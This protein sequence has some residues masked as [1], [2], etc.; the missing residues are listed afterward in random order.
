MTSTPPTTSALLLSAL[1]AYSTLAQTLFAAIES[2]SSSSR[3]TITT[4]VPD[5]VS[6]KTWSTRTVPDI[7]QA[8]EQVDILLAQRITIARQHAANQ[9]KIDK[10]Q[11]QSK[12]RNRQCRRA[13]LELSDM[14][15]DLRD[16]LGTS[17]EQVKSTR[18]A[19]RAPVGHKVI[20]AY[21]HR[22]AKYTSAPPGYKLPQ[23][24]P[25]PAP[26]ANTEPAE[27]VEGQDGREEKK[28]TLGPEYNQFASRA[29]AYYDP[30]MPSMPQE[31]PFPSDAMMRQGVL[32]SAE[33][34]NGAQ[35]ALAPKPD[36]NDD[37]AEDEPQAAVSAYTDFYSQQQH[38][39]DADDD[40]FDLDLN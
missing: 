7:L 23:I 27:G 10:L 16:L 4:S 29:A 5:P 13:I 9:A 35:M 3:R 32:N 26:P 18:R 2:P 14:K 28:L 39:R 36:T 8:L 24:A 19:Q 40:A 12:A 11:R 1:S 30:A 15:N 33:L 38:Q 31:M 34:L 17:R 20:L 22:L 21:A 6:V 25:P 37:E